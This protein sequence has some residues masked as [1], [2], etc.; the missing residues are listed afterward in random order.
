MNVLLLERDRGTS[1]GNGSIIITVG[2]LRST[3]NVRC[4]IMIRFVYEIY[5]LHATPYVQMFRRIYDLKRVSRINCTIFPQ[6]LEENSSFTTY[7]DKLIIHIV[8]SQ[9]P[10]AMYLPG[11]KVSDDI[12][13]LC[14]DGPA[15]KFPYP[16]LLQHTA[17]QNKFIRMQT[18]WYKWSFATVLILELSK[19]AIHLLKA[20]EQRFIYELFHGSACD[21]KG[22]AW[23]TPLFWFWYDRLC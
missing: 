1:M 6:Y 23:F 15:W 7:F 20:M 21:T 14:G 19:L 22:F 4:T 16:E 9:P 18:L 13:S 17:F 12:V 11:I 10:N 3:E 2:E 5:L 8:L